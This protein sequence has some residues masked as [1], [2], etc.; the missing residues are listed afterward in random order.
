MCDEIRIVVIE[1]V[2]AAEG[3]ID[4]DSRKTGEAESGLPEGCTSF[5]CGAV[6]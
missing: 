2:L 6:Q 4:H 5:G 1:M 3:V